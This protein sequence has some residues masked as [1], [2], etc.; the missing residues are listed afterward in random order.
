MYQS[1]NSTLSEI[2]LLVLPPGPEDSQI[3][4]TIYVSTLN[5]A[6]QQWIG[7]TGP[8]LVAGD[9]KPR[10]ED[11]NTT[12]YEALSY[13]WGD[14]KGPGHKIILNGQLF[15]VRENLFQALTCLRST[16]A[17]E[18]LWIDTICINQEDVQEQNHQVRIMDSIY[19]LARRVRVWIGC[20]TKRIS[21]AFQ[22]IPEIMIAYSEEEAKEVEKRGQAYRYLGHSVSHFDENLPKSSSKEDFTSDWEDLFSA[23]DNIDIWDLDYMKSTITQ[24]EGWSALVRFLERSYWTRI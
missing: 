11:S 19:R 12:H 4:G 18:S 8:E 6:H 13:E 9:W 15:K 10:K 3:E 24:K 2:R 22:L 20:D 5:P 16:G 21:D 7:R 14:P 1:L 23:H 17:T